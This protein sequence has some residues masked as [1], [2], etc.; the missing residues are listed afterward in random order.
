MT[1]GMPVTKQEK[2]EPEKEP[3]LLTALAVKVIA[4]LTVALYA[5]IAACVGAHRREGR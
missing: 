4:L 1:E 3:S 5:L 2:C